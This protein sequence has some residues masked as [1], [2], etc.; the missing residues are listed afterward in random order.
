ME[1]NEKEWK[2]QRS[3][4]FFFPR[5]SDSR[6]SKMALYSVIGVSVL[7]TQGPRKPGLLKTGGSERNA[8]YRSER[9]LM[10]YQT[11]IR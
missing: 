2:S 10:S 8:A 11:D 3:K 1:S 9:M 5:S 7:D 4:S 6:K